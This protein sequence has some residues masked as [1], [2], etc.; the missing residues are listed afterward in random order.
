MQELATNSQELAGMAAAMQEMVEK[1][2]LSQ[3]ELDIQPDMLP[4][5]KNMKGL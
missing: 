2:V 3:E 1:F 4:E 5:P